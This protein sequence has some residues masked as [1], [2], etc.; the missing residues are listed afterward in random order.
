ISVAPYLHDH[1]AIADASDGLSYLVAWDEAPYQ[2]G[3]FAAYVTH[4]GSV[5]DPSGIPISTTPVM[6]DG[7]KIASEGGG[8]SLIVYSRLDPQP[9]YG[10]SRV[11]GRFAT[12]G[13]LLGS[14]C[15]GDDACASRFCVD[16]VCCD[17]AC[18]GTCASCLAAFKVSGIDDGTCGLA[19]AG[20]D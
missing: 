17:T 4:T 12:S 13:E 15:T 1:P 5:L 18:N 7:P 11:R 6:A 19:K 14:A 2:N 20:T 3:I 8:K 9:P 10:T 16:G